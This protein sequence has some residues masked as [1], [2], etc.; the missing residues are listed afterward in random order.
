[1]KKPPL[2][3]S[4]PGIA[5]EPSASHLQ[6]AITSVPLPSSLLLPTRHEESSNSTS[7]GRP[8]QCRPSAAERAS[9]RRTTGSTI[10][11][12]SSSRVRQHRRA[13]TNK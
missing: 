13:S 11:V 6:C 2:P 3:S 1:M 12:T 10:L 7:T 9:E 4:S 5:H 8:A